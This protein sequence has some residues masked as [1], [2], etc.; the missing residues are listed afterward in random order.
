MDSSPWGNFTPPVKQCGETLGDLEPVYHLFTIM[1]EVTLPL[2]ATSAEYAPKSSWEKR[3]VLLNAEKTKLVLGFL[4]S[5]NHTRS[6]QDESYIHSYSIP[7]Q[8]N[9][10]SKHKFKKEKKKKAAHN[11]RHNTIN[12]KHNQHQYL[13]F[14]YLQLRKIQTGVFSF[15][16]HFSTKLK[17]SNHKYIYV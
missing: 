14:T 7:V 4:H 17:Q 13:H 10:P 2:A 8:N 1:S 11:S 9:K 12:S 3:R 16:D 15:A 5:V 6:P